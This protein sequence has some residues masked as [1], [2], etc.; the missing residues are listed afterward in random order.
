[1]DGYPG[2]VMARWNKWNKANPEV[3][4]CFEVKAWNLHTRGHKKY[5]ARRIVESMRWDMDIMGAGDPFLINSDF[6]PIMA[7]KFVEKAPWMKGFF[8]FREVRSRGI[9]S[10]EQKKREANHAD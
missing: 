10:S 2:S 4:K 8:E 1:M 6:V 3:Y 7:R 5:S 9:K